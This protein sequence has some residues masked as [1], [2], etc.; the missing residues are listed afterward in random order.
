MAAS[1]TFPAEFEAM[2]SPRGLRVLGGDDEAVGALARGVFFSADD[3]LD[4]RRV[5]A[6]AGILQRA[7]G[8]CLQEMSNTLPEVKTASTVSAGEA[9]HKVGRL[10]TTPMGNSLDRKVVHRARECGLLG[11]LQSPSYHAFAQA[12]AGRKVDGPGSMQVLCYRPGDYAGPHTDHHP[13]S[14]DHRDGYVDVHLTFCTPG[15]REQL[16]VYEENGHLSA[17]RSIAKSGTVTAYRLPFWHYTT[18]LQGKPEARR[19][20]VLGSF[21]DAK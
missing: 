17:Q 11:M 4:A 21:T 18:P 14:A 8:E 9:L 19:W 6:G 2:L 20:L 16:I 15:V 7:L 5:R 12:L 1:K 3:L 13:E 10:L